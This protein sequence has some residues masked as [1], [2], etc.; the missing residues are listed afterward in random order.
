MLLAEC[1]GALSLVFWK[2]ELCFQCC[3]TLEV[4]PVVCVSCF[5]IAWVSTV[6]LS[7]CLRLRGDGGC[8]VKIRWNLRAFRSDSTTSNLLLTEIWERG[9][10]SVILCMQ[11]VCRNDVWSVVSAVLNWTPVVRQFNEYVNAVLM[12]FYID[13][14]R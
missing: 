13:M 8:C 14:H 9:D 6:L 12:Y 4:S 7:F 10:Q 5:V 11:Y 3:L 2:R 1:I